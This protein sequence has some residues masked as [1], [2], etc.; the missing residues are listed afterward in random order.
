[1]RNP[2]IIKT[3]DDV[4]ASIERYESAIKA[5]GTPPNDEDKRN[6]IISKL[7]EVVQD[8]VM[9]KEFASFAELKRFLQEHTQRIEDLGIRPAVTLNAM[10]ETEAERE[11]AQEEVIEAIQMMLEGGG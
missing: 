8:K 9:F 4:M 7:P 5:G 2:N 1:M 11:Q 10:D 6:I 3:V